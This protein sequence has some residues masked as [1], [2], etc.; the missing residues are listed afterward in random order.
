[1]LIKDFM[2]QKLPAL[3]VAFGFDWD[4]SLYRITCDTEDEEWLKFK[5]EY[6][7]LIGSCNDWTHKDLILELLSI[8]KE[9]KQ[10]VSDCLSDLHDEQMHACHSWN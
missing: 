9:F 10:M 1:M 8:E 5:R 7:S 6:L 2:V 4:K 3:N